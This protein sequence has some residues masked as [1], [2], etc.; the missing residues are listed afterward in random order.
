M[1]KEL[2]HWQDYKDAEGMDKASMRI[3]VDGLRRWLVKHEEI[4]ATL[5]PEQ[6]V[7]TRWD[8]LFGEE[9]AEVRAAIAEIESRLEGMTNA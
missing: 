1:I 3:V 8:E 6:R 2:R 9:E 7:E 5:T 4:T